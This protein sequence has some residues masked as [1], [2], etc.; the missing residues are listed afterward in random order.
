[1][2]RIRSYLNNHN[3]RK[4]LVPFFT[5]GFPNMKQF[6]KLVHTSIDS[7]A[8]FVEIGMPFSDPLADGPEIQYSSYQAL[9]NGITLKKILNSVEII[10]KSSD[11]PLIL[12]GYYN[13]ILTYG[14]KKFM[15]D[16]H[17]SGVDGLIIPDLPIDEAKSF[18]QNAEQN[19]LSIVFLVAPTSSDERIKKIDQLCSDFVYAVT[20]TGVTGS[21]KTFDKSTDSYLKKLK[22][23]LKK[24]FVAGFGVSSAETAQRLARYSS[25]VVIGSKLVTII[26]DK[27]TESQAIKSVATLLT[28]IR[29]ALG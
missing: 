17:A 24:K 23:S 6:L 8:D 14:E 20:V 28:Q 13:P 19:N 22:S 18:K 9:K 4:L 3:G 15:K 11:T 21:G 10:R 2:N 25:G 26:R 1:M 27:K 29:R 5:A 16:A 12:M 7:G